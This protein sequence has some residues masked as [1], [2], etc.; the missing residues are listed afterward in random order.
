MLGLYC[1]CVCPSL[2]CVWLFVT[3]WTVARQAP[4]SMGF[5]RQGYWSGL[6]FPSPGDFPVPGI[7]P[8]SP[9]SSP[10][11]PPGLCLPGWNS[12]TFVRTDTPLSTTLL[13]YSIHPKCLYH[14]TFFTYGRVTCG[15]WELSLGSDD[16]VNPQSKCG[17]PGRGKKKKTLLSWHGGKIPSWVGK[18][19]WRRAWQP[20]PVFLPGESQGQRSLAGYSSW[21]HNNNASIVS[22]HYLWAMCHA[23]RQR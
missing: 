14:L 23:N 17:V 18:I 20:T 6:Q 21:G 16:Q 22:A 10:S 4:L 9:D 11:E 3:P 1:H 2:S 5:S 8:R 7:E 13:K 15:L 12:S 19:P